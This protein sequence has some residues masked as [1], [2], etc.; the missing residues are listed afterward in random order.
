MISSDVLALIE[1]VADKLEVL[2]FNQPETAIKLQRIALLLENQTKLNVRKE[3]LVRR[4]GL[5]NSITSRIAI[6]SKDEAIVSYGSVGV[7]Y[8]AYHEYGFKGIMD[9]RSHSRKS[10]KGTKFNVGGY[11]RRVDYDGRPFIRPSLIEHR[12]RILQILNGDR[13]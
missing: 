5:I 7:N 11:S 2:D 10:K 13:N 3:S 12:R 9:V 4:G 1:R 8:A 6:R